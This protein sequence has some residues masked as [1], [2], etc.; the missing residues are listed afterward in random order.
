MLGSTTVM[1]RSVS[2]EKKAAMPQSLCLLCLRLPVITNIDRD[3]RKSYR[4]TLSS[5]HT[6]PCA[7]TASR[8][9]L[10]PATDTG[11]HRLV[12]AQHRHSRAI[13]PAPA[14]RHAPSVSS[15]AHSAPDPIPKSPHDTR[16]RHPKAVLKLSHS[17][18]LH[19]LSAVHTQ[20]SATCGTRGP[21]AVSRESRP[22]V[23][24][25]CGSQG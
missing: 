16:P 25:E 8:P 12:T 3:Y 20:K 18:P 21:S 15:R 24:S 22:E 5:D 7:Q 19:R 14:A 13:A 10:T 2:L 4:G 6:D 11:W 17:R 9:R 1:C 23:R